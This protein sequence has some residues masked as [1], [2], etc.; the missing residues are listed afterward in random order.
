MDMYTQPTILGLFISLE[1]CGQIVR[2][3]VISM[4]H[5]YSDSV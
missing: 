3:S 4:C 5:T 2:D 1:A